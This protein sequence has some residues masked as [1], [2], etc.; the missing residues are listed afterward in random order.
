MLKYIP[1]VARSATL[2][3]CLMALKGWQTEKGVKPKS[4]MSKNEALDL[5]D[6][7]FKK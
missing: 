6:K 4:T 1:S 3:D 5:W 7:G 2:K